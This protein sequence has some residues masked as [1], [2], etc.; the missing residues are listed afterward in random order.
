VRLRGSSLI[1]RGA[2]L[3]FAILAVIL[4]TFQLVRYSLLRADYPPDMT[5]A[6]VSVG[7]TDPQTAE[8][9]LL[10]VYS[11]PVELDYGSAVID[12]APNVIGFQL[13]TDS[14]LAAADLQRTGSSFWGGFW[15]YLWNRRS[16]ASQ[17]PLVATYSE[18]RLRDYLRDE[19]ASRYD[20]PSIPAQPIPGSSNYNP[21]TPGQ[22]LDIDRAVT[23][24]ESAMQSPTDRKVILSSQSTAPG[25]PSLQQLE[26]QLKSI[27]AANGFN[28]LVDLY[29]LDLQTAQELHFATQA[30]QD[31]SLSPEISF[32]ASG[33][34]M[35]PIMVTTYLYYNSKL[36][37][38][39]SALLQN[40]IT[41]SDN[42]AA[43]TLSDNTAADALMEGINKAR[44]PLL[45]SETMKKLGLAN[46]FLAG[47][48]FSGAPV[49]ELFNTPGNSRPD[50]NTNPDTHKQT[51][52]A[53]MGMLLED[54]YQCSQVGGGALVAA[55]PG[56]IDQAACQQMIQ[57]LELDKVGV[58]LETG[59]PDGT[60]VAHQHGWVTDLTGVMHTVC[61]AAII[62]TPGG[63]YILSVYSYHPNQII[64]ED[65][66]THLGINHMYGDISRAV[67]NYFNLPTQ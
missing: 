4:T 31:V 27:I 49:L 2:S 6:G 3:L 29:F 46:T 43:D 7:G 22:N 62:Y 1:L 61:D 44:G 18:Q 67:Y 59:V 39:T 32:G 45:V 51:T 34:I 12:L 14:M 65:P 24:I 5:I 47:Y 15:D 17:I 11:I 54:I 60:A 55:F 57:T 58:L 56:Q 41:L 63:N 21:G 26:V 50:I 66:T 42:T 10:Q 8:Q 64:W 20:Q 38:S 13:N 23:L 36:D 16:A 52:P 48:F 30:G 53:D 28:G 19:I 25:R 35:I 9:R 37:P 40:M 33:T